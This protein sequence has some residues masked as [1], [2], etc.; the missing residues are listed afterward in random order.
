MLKCGVD[1]A[2]DHYQG[3]YNKLPAHQ[4]DVSADAAEGRVK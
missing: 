1:L 2:A 3:T 4:P